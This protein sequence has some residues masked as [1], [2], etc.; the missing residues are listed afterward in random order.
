MGEVSNLDPGGGQV[1]GVG[2]PSYR[3]SAGG[4]NLKFMKPEVAI[5]IVTWNGKEDCISCLNSLRDLVPPRPSIIVVDN[6]STDGTAGMVTKHFPGV[7][8]ITAPVNLGFAGG[9]NLGIERA[10]AEGADYVCLLNNDTVVDP[11]FLEELLRVAVEDPRTGILGSRILYHDRPDRVWSQGIAVNR[12]SGRIYTTY[13]NLKDSE[14]S[15]IIT[16]VDAVS[17]ASMLLKREMLREVGL[18]DEDY[19]LCFEDVDF[20]LRAGRMGYKRVTVSSSRVWHKVSSSMGG[21]YS[22]MTVYYATRNHLLVG[23]KQLGGTLILRGIR[24]SLIM[25][26]T[27]IFAAVTSGAPRGPKIR[28]WRQG[29]RDYFRGR[30]GD[31]DG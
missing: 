5:V 6:G 26:Y 17:G 20:C 18:L 7:T 8:I 15:G 12:I 30:F 16:E 27:L 29:V 24:S 14:V 31:R 28:A 22:E 25:L 1:I 9:N 3:V 21:E 4:A 19:Y 23:K 13:N 10:L 2:N 11:H